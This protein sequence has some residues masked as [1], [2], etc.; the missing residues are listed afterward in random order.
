VIAPWPEPVERVAAFLRAA[1]AEARLE[2]FRRGTPT[3]EAAAEAVG[4][5]LGQIVKSL[6]LMA[7]GAPLVALVPGDREA[8]TTKVARAIGRKHARIARREEVVAVAGEEPGAVSPFALQP[9]PPILLE[10]TLLRHRV[11]WCGAGSTRHMAAVAPAELQ[12]VTRAE[13]ADIV[14]E[15]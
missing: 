13:L 15:R 3:A 11:V 5:T 6:V 10:R 2:E 8:N 12:R 9:A 14:G 4:C 1:G 7:D